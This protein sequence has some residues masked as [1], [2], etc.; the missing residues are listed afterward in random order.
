[1]SPLTLTG[2]FSLSSLGD[3]EAFGRRLGKLLFPNAVVAMIGGLGAGKTHLS[4]AIAEGLEVRNPMAVTSPTFVLIQEYPA[5]LPIFH[6]DAYRLATTTDFLELGAYEYYTMGGVCLIEWADRVGDAMPTERLE[7][8]LT[9]T[10]EES[11]QIN[12]TASGE[13]YVRLLTD[14][15]AIGTRNGL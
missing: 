3:T 11:R 14:M 1:M 15:I 6:F 7:L 4:R 10:G 9:T 5:R 13:E 2:S 8:V 12:A